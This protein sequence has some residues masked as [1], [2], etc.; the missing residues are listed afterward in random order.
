MIAWSLLRPHLLAAVLGAAAAGAAWR[1]AVAVERQAQLEQSLQQEQ[2]ERHRERDQH[3]AELGRLEAHH[4]AEADRLR[5]LAYHVAAQ[6]EAA[7]LA[8]PPSHDGARR[9][10]ERRVAYRARLADA[11]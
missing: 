11:P 2:D 5:R 9:S 8:D 4:Q 3:A 6:R 1:W 10:H 7:T